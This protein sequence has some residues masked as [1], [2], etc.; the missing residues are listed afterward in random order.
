MFQGKIEGL[1]SILGVRR[2]KEP[3]AKGVDRVNRPNSMVKQ[4][5]YN[6]NAHLKSKSGFL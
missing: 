3:V 4:G 2:A 1:G 6:L 5:L